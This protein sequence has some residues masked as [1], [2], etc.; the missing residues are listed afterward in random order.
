VTSTALQGVTLSFSPAAVA[1][2]TTTATGGY[3]VTLPV[4][5][6][7]VTVTDS[8]FEEAE[9]DLIVLA[10][11]DQTFDIALDPN[12]PVIVDAGADLK[13]AAG[14]NVQPTAT[15]EILDGST[16]ATYLWKQ[17]SG[18][19]LTITGETTASPTITLAS[20]ADYKKELA[21]HAME[22][23]R[24]MIVGIA[25]MTA[26]ET[27]T[28]VFEVTVTTSSGSYK[29]TVN[30]VADLGIDW[31][32]GI[33]NVA[34]QTSVVMQAKE[35]TTAGYAWTLTGPT[36]STAKLDE[37]TS[38]W[39]IFV[40]DL[41]GTYKVTETKSGDTMDIIAGKWK[42][43]ISGLSATDG[44]PEAKD[45]TL[46]HNG[47]VA[48]KDKFDEWRLSGHAEI[49]SQNQNN[50]DNHWSTGCAS[51]HG[52]GYNEG[53]TNNGW[54]EQMAAESWKT[55][56]GDVNNYKNMFTT[57]PKTASMGNIQCE[58]CHGPN[59]STAH[60][61]S[62]VEKRVSLSSDV[63]GSCHGEPLR[64]ARF[65]QW[66]ESR[67]GSYDNA[68]QGAVEVRGASAGHCGRCHTANGF[69]E[70]TKQGTFDKRLQ[71]AAGDA[72]EAELTAMGLTENNVHPVTCVACHDPHNPGDTSGEPNTTT[73][74]VM[75]NTGMLAAGF[76][77]V[78][79]GKGATCM[80]CHNTRNGKK[81]G[82]VTASSAPHYSAQADIMMGENAYFVQ[83]GIRGKHSYIANTCT[84]CHMELTDP[85]KELS[86]NLSGTNHTFEASMKI[87]SSCHGKYDGGTIKA[88][89][90]AELEKLNHAMGEAAKTKLTGLGKIWIRAYDANTD[91][92]SSSSSSSYNV[93]LDFAANPIDHIGITH[94]HGQ[95]ELHFVMTNA[96]TITWSD[97]TQTTTKEFGAQI[98]AVRLDNAGA[99]GGAVYSG[100]G[101]FWK[102]GWNLL[103]L[104]G[105]GSHGIHNPG[106]FLQVI[107]NTMA[108]DLS[109]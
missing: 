40:P 27:E 109:N 69:I 54:D 73:V 48:F 63:C 81:G 10:G 92:Y 15:N 21:K 1:D 19:P 80:V 7:K 107:A 26:E 96:M 84:T 56:K 93:A 90:M 85:P 23:D 57:A 87:C 5:V 62:N 88:A 105:D 6:Y 98:A 106:F 22:P 86:Y 100:S 74:R 70:W 58:N 45:C 12:K 94:G 101:N 14:A 20:L 29:D 13:G 49:F 46:C 3:S 89:N 95:I 71:G 68:P 31:S 52:V 99:A 33:A 72:T 76:E 37:A 103:L 55:P 43:A 42:G 51:C 83:T 91:L 64:H 67:H 35:D 66:Q 11:Q 4:G 17:K 34:V 97:A 104:E 41:P 60:G 61:G 32:T 79:V 102:A 39:P 16:G 8:N 36:G 2:Q 75:N 30:V 82:T 25:P 78:G 47:T 18:V 24:F 108:Q 50:P 44:E 53:A 38:R 28:A 65:Q 9:L 77:A 59:D